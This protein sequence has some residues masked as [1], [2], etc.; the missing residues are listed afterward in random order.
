MSALKLSIVD[1]VPVHNDKNQAAA[2]PDCIKL[3]K[4]AD[5]LGYHRYWIAEHHST[6]SYASSS[7]EIVIGQIAANTRNIR[8]GSGGVMLSHYSPY[9][10]AEVFKTLEAF[11]PGRI[12]LGVG[13]A[14]GGSEHSSLALAYPNYPTEPEHFP[15]LLEALVGFID[16][17]SS[18]ANKNFPG[19]KTTP[20]GGNTPELWTLGSSDGSIE[21]AAAN[22]LGFVLALFIGTH[23]RPAD[24]IKRYRKMYRPRTEISS[25][26]APAI[27]ANAVI[28]ADTKEEAEL[29]AASHTYWKVQAFRHGIREGIKPPETCMDLLKK[30]SIS[31]QA[32]FH[33]TRNSMITGTADQCRQALED[34]ATYYGVNEVMIVAVTH[35]FEK[36]YA[37]YQKLAEIFS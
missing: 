14:P 1:Q 32:Y 19:L 26:D 13:R 25:Q 10:V 15:H 9:K 34:Q 7:P 22:G 31:D 24:I 35:D 27:I 18:Q 29:L 16:E 5:D 28:C 8:I 4:L 2:L 33:E 20:S 23:E 37:S 30:L 11:N 17:Q 12:D 6:P 36:R 21:L 3:A